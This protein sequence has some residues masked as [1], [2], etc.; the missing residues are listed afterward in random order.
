MLL[1][2]KSSPAQLTLCCCPGSGPGTHPKGG[3]WSIGVHQYV[4]VFPHLVRPRDCSGS[5]P[6][7]SAGTT[8]VWCFDGLQ[9][10][11]LLCRTCTEDSMDSVN[12]HSLLSPL[13]RIILM[14]MPCTPTRCSSCCFTTEQAPRPISTR[15][16]ANYLQPGAARL[17]SSIPGQT[18][19]NQAPTLP[20]PIDWGWIK[21][22][23]MYKPLW[24]MLPKASKICWELV[25][26]KEGCVKSASARMPGWNAPTV[27]LQWWGCSQN[28]THTL[29]TKILNFS[30]QCTGTV[31]QW[32]HQFCILHY[33]D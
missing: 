32:T 1:T 20:S 8:D 9:H 6:W 24:T 3:N 5:G 21:T 33:A 17:T 28:W 11:L 31:K 26:C 29:K 2:R 14:K 18:C 13:H 12:W 7:E 15:H 30:I 4:E 16:A 25:S 27:C 19:L 23:S 22:S 10:G